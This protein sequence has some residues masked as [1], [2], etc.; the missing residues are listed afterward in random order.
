MDSRK[1]V[2]G[3]IAELL[4]A[5]VCY[6]LNT[7]KVR[8]QIGLRLTR[9]GIFK[10]FKWCLLNEFVDSL[11]F[12]SVAESSKSFSLAS[13]CS[14]TVSYPLYVRT[15]LLQSGKVGNGGFYHGFGL[16]LL[17]SVPGTTLNYTI[18]NKI[19]KHV[20]DKYNWM[21]GYLGTGISLILTH[22]LSTLSTLVITRHKVNPIKLLKYDGFGFRALEQTISV[23][24]K[25]LVMDFLNG[26]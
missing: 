25:M 10:G 12:F 24:S 17:N 21:S 14:N 7:W 6:P 2:N 1:V 18:K 11:V 23:G 26:L 8:R 5:T 4:V 15:K 13:I 22:P 20:P 19:S 9:D 3:I 16:S